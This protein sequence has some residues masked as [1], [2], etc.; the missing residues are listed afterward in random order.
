MDPRGFWDPG[1]SVAFAV[2]AQRIRPGSV[3]HLKRVKAAGWRNICVASTTHGDILDAADTIMG[4]GKE[5]RTPRPHCRREG[6]ALPARC[7]PARGADCRLGWKGVPFVCAHS[8][9]RG[10]QEAFCPVTGFSQEALAW[11]MPENLR[12]LGGSFASDNSIP[13]ALKRGKSGSA[14][15]PQR[16]SLASMTAKDASMAGGAAAEA[17][18][19]GSS[20]RGDTALPVVRIWVRAV[21]ISFRPG[22]SLLSRRWRTAAFSLC[23]PV[24]LSLWFSAL[25]R[26]ELRSAPPQTTLLCV[27][28]L[29][30]MDESY[31]LHTVEADGFEETIVDR[32]MDWL[33]LQARNER[34][35]IAT[36]DA[37]GVTHAAS[38][39]GAGAARRGW[40]LTLRIPL[41]PLPSRLAVR[42]RRA[43]RGHQGRFGEAGG[44]AARRVGEAPR[45]EPF[46]LPRPF[47]LI[48]AAVSRAL[49]PLLRVA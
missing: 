44:S 28:V 2:C 30:R 36:P 4:E 32:A 41:S 46:V 42:G 33:D 45:A 48:S 23:E 5:V 43:P 16:V 1:A 14:A 8:H 19:C 39:S 13:S 6:S 26:S 47:A 38:R 35:V 7:D 27:R 18:A 20:V 29:L 11:S 31:L 22:L 37:C 15:V 49:R 34:S 40:L 24:A 12:E 10:A 3:E 21:S 9:R 25:R 17:R